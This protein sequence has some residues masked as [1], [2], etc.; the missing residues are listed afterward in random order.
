V[1]AIWNVVVN[2]QRWPP[3]FLGPPLGF[4]II[5]HAFLL[6]CIISMVSIRL[7]HAL[8]L[9]LVTSWSK[10]SPRVVSPQ[11]RGLRCTCHYSEITKSCS[12]W[13]QIS[14]EYSLNGSLLISSL[15]RRFWQCQETNHIFRGQD[16]C[17]Q[18]RRQFWRRSY[19]SL[20]SWSWNAFWNGLCVDVIGLYPVCVYVIGLYV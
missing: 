1:Q 2:L 5:A 12:Y 8:L 14:Q 18:H 19:P 13:I 11:R 7:C 17:W 20:P 9:L 3:G 6:L 16:Q 15:L 4:L 10:S